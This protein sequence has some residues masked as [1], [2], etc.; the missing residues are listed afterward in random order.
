MT[1]DHLAT[2]SAETAA[3]AIAAVQAFLEDEAA[4]AKPARGGV[5]SWRMAVLGAGAARG[6]GANVTWRGRD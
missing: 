2:T 6:F 3:A 1:N 4:R 5:S